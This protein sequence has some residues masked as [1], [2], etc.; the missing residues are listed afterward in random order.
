MPWLAN[1]LV[2]SHDKKAPALRRALL[3]SATQRTCLRALLSLLWSFPLFCKSLSADSTRLYAP[4]P[5]H[6]RSCNTQWPGCLG[7]R[8]TRLRYAP[9]DPES[10]CLLYSNTAPVR[11]PLMC[12]T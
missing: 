1:S 8:P 6:P 12:G 2:A 5:D 7:E 9:L 11:H 4:R 10:S 3:N